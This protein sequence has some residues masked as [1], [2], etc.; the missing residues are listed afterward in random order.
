MFQF[1]YDQLSK[2]GQNGIN[3][4]NALRRDLTT[5]AN[6]FIVH[7]ENDKI[8]CLTETEL[9]G[10]ELLIKGNGILGFKNEAKVILSTFVNNFPST[11]VWL[12]Q[13]AGIYK[14]KLIDSQKSGY[15]AYHTLEG[16]L[17]YKGDWKSDL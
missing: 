11:D 3:I 15:G 17:L 6:K 1:L 12:Y 16:G 9:T 7:N 14:G 13:P 2:F 4:L 5:Y 8:Y 10:N